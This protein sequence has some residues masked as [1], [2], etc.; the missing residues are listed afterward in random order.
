MSDILNLP[1]ASRAPA[2][3][4]AQAVELSISCRDLGVRFF[5]ERRSVTAIK[6]LN[7]DVAAGEFLTLLGPSGCGK[8]TLLRVVADLIQPDDG[9][10]RVFGAAPDAARLRRD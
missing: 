3:S 6:G 8:S 5:P 7:L 9:E 4:P 1:A 2:Q 10:I